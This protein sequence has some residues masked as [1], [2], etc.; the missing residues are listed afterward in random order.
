METRQGKITDEKEI[1]NEEKRFYQCL[2]TERN[3]AAS[4]PSNI[5]NLFLQNKEI[6]K[7]SP[8]DKA[9]CDSPLT[10]VE[11]SKALKE[12]KNNKSPGCDGLPVEFYKFF[13][14]YFNFLNLK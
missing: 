2:Y 3:C 11:C 5:E 4:A 10:L 12:L 9:I 6:K 7:L 14:G 13:G 8:T 1:L